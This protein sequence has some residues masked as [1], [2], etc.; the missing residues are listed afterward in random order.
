MVYHISWFIFVDV[1]QKIE[2]TLLNQHS[3]WKWPFIVSCPIKN[4]DFPSF[5]HRFFYVYQRVARKRWSSSSPIGR[6]TKAAWNGWR[7]ATTPS[8]APSES[9][10]E[11]SR[12]KRWTSRCVEPGWCKETKEV[13]WIMKIL[14]ILVLPGLVNIQKKNNWNMAIDSEFSQL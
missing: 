1:S 10:S 9:T 13:T 12:G 6:W 8:V 5:F 2:S 11:T 7:S 14:D 3:Y 4:D